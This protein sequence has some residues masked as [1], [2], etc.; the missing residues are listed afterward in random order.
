MAV[1]GK[2]TLY[3]QWGP[4]ECDP[5]RDG[6]TSGTAFLVSTPDALKY[7]GQ[8]SSSDPDYY[9]RWDLGKYY[10]LNE[11]IDMD[12]ESFPQ[13]GSLVGPFTGTFDGK[14][15]TISNIDMIPDAP[16]EP[17]GLFGVNDGTIRN[18]GLDGGSTTTTSIWLNAGLVGFNYGIVENCYVIGMDITAD[19]SAGALVGFNNGILRN[20]YAAENTIISSIS[21]GIGGLVGLIASGTVQNCY[22]TGSVSGDEYVGGVAGFFS[23]GDLINC[24]AL[25]QTVKNNNTTNVGR[26]VGFYISGS[27]TN[28]YALETMVLT[29]ALTLSPPGDPDDVHGKD[30]S[31]AEA[32]DESW[33]RSTADWDSAWG[34]TSANETKPWKMGTVNGVSRPVLWYQ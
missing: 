19:S 1:A 29:P 2:V 5:P 12:R 9:K 34:G 30:V 21:S 10:E 6:N 11:D 16:G 26:V 28:N 15:H 4:P 3:A 27:M 7:V 33:W 8:G 13:I 20:C 31:L 25:M 23:G 24:V 22:I 18:L 17:L 14:G 32:A